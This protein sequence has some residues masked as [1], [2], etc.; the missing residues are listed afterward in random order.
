M[1]VRKKTARSTGMGR[2]LL[3]LRA[4][5]DSALWPEAVAATNSINRRLSH[6]QDIKEVKNEL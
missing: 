1:D 3:S 2:G 5:A 4:I 6:V